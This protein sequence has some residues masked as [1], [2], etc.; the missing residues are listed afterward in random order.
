MYCP[1][2]FEIND[3]L[4]F[5]FLSIYINRNT[6]VAICRENMLGYLPA[7]IIC[8]EKRTGSSRKTVSYDYSVS[9]ILR[10]RSVQMRT[11]ASSICSLK[12]FPLVSSCILIKLIL[13]GRHAFSFHLAAQV[14]KISRRVY[15][16]CYDNFLAGSSLAQTIG[17]KIMLSS[18]LENLVNRRRIAIN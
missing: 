1:Y 10:G 16:A 6:V 13:K 11:R 17:E 3:S 15:H 2:N 8:S 7:D 5:P 4:Y 18:T 9:E 14:R 12:L